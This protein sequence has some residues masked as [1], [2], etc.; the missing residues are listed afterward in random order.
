ME[1]TEIKGANTLTVF[2]G[3]SLC[4][5]E[6]VRKGEGEKDKNRVK[7]QHSSFHSRRPR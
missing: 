5:G 7:G 2:F 3:V 6:R 1:G 4:V